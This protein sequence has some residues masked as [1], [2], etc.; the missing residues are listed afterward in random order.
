MIK[1]QILKGFRDSLPKDEIQRKE[2]IRVIEDSFSSHG[3]VPI[4]TP[5]LEYTEVL[6]G[7]GGGETD[8]QIFSFKDN[9]NRDVAMRF[10]LTVPFARFIALHENEVNFPFKRYHIAKVFR[11][12]KP[13]KGRYREFF[14]CDFDIIGTQSVYSD[15]EIIEMIQDSLNNLG[16]SEFKI[17][18]NHR[19]IFNSFLEKLNIKDKSTLILREV[20]K[21]SKIGFDNVKKELISIIEDEDKVNKVLEFI[22]VDENEDFLTTLD[23]LEK[24][25]CDKENCSRLKDI[26]LLCSSVLNS[27]NLVLN[28][29]ITRG[30]D[31][32]TGIVFETF[33][34]KLPSIG[35]ICSGGRYDNLASLYTKSVISGVGASI[36]LDRLLAAL[37]ELES[38]N[39]K[40][41]TSDLVI[42]LDNNTLRPWAYQIAKVLRE[43][44]IKVDVYCEDKSVKAQVKYAKNNN[45]SYTIT[46]NDEMKKNNKVNLKRTSD[47]TFFNDLTISDL[48][49]TLE[50]ELF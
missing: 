50:K 20:D 14:Q 30:L 46:L 33:L 23:R 19:Q 21:L 42:L 10:D 13:Q 15:Y 29:S 2:T 9:G 35:S 17:H 40:T 45:I 7:K 36:G 5:I 25:S 4:D 44:D 11:G 39:E 49:T 38:S 26:Y 34:D 31:Y 6:L 8:K 24:L 27:S 32:Y 1:P 12:E 3:F 28:P 37:N 43:N 47:S 41:N 22:K 16:V 18:V 48:I